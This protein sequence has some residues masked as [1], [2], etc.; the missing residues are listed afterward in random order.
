MKNSL[1]PKQVGDFVHKVQLVRSKKSVA[2]GKCLVY[3]TC[4]SMREAA[5][6]C[7]ALHGFTYPGMTVEPMEAIIAKPPPEQ[8]AGLQYIP[9]VVH[10]TPEQQWVPPELAHLFVRPYS[11]PIPC[12]ETRIA[13]SRHRSMFH[14]GD[15]AQCFRN[16]LC[17]YIGLGFLFICVIFIDFL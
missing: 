12:M 9:P 7:E 10:R 6:V 1:K 3:I 5:W 13:N 11:G 17:V 14:D 4:T 16:K 8:E 15:S 2:A